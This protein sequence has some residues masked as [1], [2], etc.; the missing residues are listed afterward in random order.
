[1]L[2][3]GEAGLA[4]VV[5]I[6]IIIVF[7][8]WLINLGNRECRSNN[9]CKSDSYC[10]SDFACHKIPVIEKTPVI[11]QR[12]YNAAAWVIGIAM[13]VS[14]LILRWE[15]IFGSGLGRI[16]KRKKEEKQETLPEYQY[17]TNIPPS[18]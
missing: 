18:K 13:V 2:K 11:V 14:A 9:E 7:F 15:K 3:K 12:D 1:M 17:Y 6:I 10:G 16:F 5:I 4:A 8:G